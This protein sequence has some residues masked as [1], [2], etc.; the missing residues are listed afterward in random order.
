MAVTPNTGSTPTNISVIL[1]PGGLT[2][3]IYRGSID[4]TSPGL[5][6]PATIPVTLTVTSNVTVSANPTSLA[7]AMALNGPNPEA[8]VL[9]IT[10]SDGSTRGF[11]AAASGGSWLSV[12]PTTASTGTPLS[13][14]VNGAGLS[15]G[16]YNGQI[17][18]S[19]PGVANP[20]LTVPVTF[21]IGPP[22]TVSATP[23]NLAFVYQIGGPN[24]Q[25]QNISVTSTGGPVNI[26]VGVTVGSNIGWLSV[27]PLSGATPQTLAAS[28]NPANLNVGTHSGT[29]A[30]SAPGVLA[31]PINIQVTLTVQARPA[32]LPTV[33]T[34]SA[35]NLAG[36]VAPGEI[37]AIKGTLLGPTTGVSFQL[38]QQGT[39]DTTLAGV[40]VLFSGIP[41]IPTFVRADQ[42]NVVAPFEIAG[43]LTVLVVVENNGV[44][45]APIE[46]RVADVAPAIYTASSTGQG[47]GAIRNQD[48][49]INGAPGPGVGPAAP[50]S[51]IQVFGTGGGQTNPPSVTGTV[52]TGL[53]HTITATATVGGRP[54]TVNFSGG[55]PGLVAGGWQCNLVLPS[56]LPPGD[57]EVII[58]L[59]GVSTPRGVTVRVQ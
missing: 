25:S 33:V 31:Q 18:V 52:T 8:R 45:S 42:V 22:Q 27:T 2:P 37:L 12:N 17:T 26:S 32:P 10:T 46:V 53:R 50:G 49:S 35:S 20:T 47:Q 28:V 56:D 44:A 1:F 16:T 41:G 59:G 58:T 14:S 9:N 36:A 5:P 54:V 24:P 11:T 13:V 3:G 15:P 23:P 6:A 29:I 34:N 39:Y 48:N 38:N 43:R 19:T 51:V 57:H 40:R 30:I 21:T 55:A 4:I 7:F